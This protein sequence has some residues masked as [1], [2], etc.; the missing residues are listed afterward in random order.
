M[1]TYRI[2]ESESEQEASDTSNN[3]SRSR[4]RVSLRC[5]YQCPR[6]LYTPHRTV[7]GAQKRLVPRFGR[8]HRH[9]RPSALMM[10]VALP[11][12]PRPEKQ[13]LWGILSSTTVARTL[14]Y[15]SLCRSDV[16]GI[17]FA[18]NNTGATACNNGTIR[19]GP[20][21]GLSLGGLGDFETCIPN[22]TTEHSR[23]GPVLFWAT[24]L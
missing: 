21:S 22:S 9:D 19:I 18:N 7:A 12:T 8:I 20:P 13:V 4:K 10:A 2:D 5:L 17:S 6:E 23:H 3:Q 24:T 16:D 1:K 11:V 15:H 14:R